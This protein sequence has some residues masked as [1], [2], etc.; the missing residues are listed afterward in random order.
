MAYDQFLIE[1]DAPVNSRETNNALKILLIAYNKADCYFSKG[2]LNS[3]GIKLVNIAMRSIIKKHPQY[4][5]YFKKLRK[6]KSY[7]HFLKLLGAVEAIAH[8]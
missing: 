8:Q 6:S 2:Y 5:V 7:E 3:E 4:I 1:S